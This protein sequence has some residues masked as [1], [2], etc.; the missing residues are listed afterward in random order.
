MFG[1]PGNKEI[2]SGLF[3]HKLMGFGGIAAGLV[4]RLLFP[5]AFLVRF[6]QTGHGIKGLRIKTFLF[7]NE[8]YEKKTEQ[9]NRNT[10]LTKVIMI[11]FQVLTK[12]V[13]SFI[14]EKTL[15]RY[16]RYTHGD[17]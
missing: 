11:R 15:K 2:P 9:N 13:R 10:I 5:V 4:H 14:K 3:E 8:K 6:K 17:N 12:K 1:L 16:W 7:S